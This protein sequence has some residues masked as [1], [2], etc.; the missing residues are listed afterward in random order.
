[1]DI[2][3]FFKN[4]KFYLN[5][6]NNNHKLITDIRNIEEFKLDSTDDSD[7]IDDYFEEMG[8]IIPKYEAKLSIDSDPLFDT[9]IKIPEPVLA[10]FSILD[11]EVIELVLMD[12]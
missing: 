7:L 6:R 8:E 3:N 2:N 1:M 4:I 5:K 12:R 11:K 10:D 9:S